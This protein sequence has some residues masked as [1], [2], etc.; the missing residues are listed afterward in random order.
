M[1]SC[2]WEALLPVFVLVGIYGGFTTPSEAAA[3]TA[4][5]ILIVECFIYKD[6][7]LF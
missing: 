4:F 6:V 3:I 7:H 5:Y 1:R 2:I